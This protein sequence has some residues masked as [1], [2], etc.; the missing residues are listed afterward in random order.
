MASV[1]Q[2][3]KLEIS[4]KF[5][6]TIAQVATEVYQSRNLVGN[7]FRDPAFSFLCRS[8]GDVIANL[9]S[10]RQHLFVNDDCENSSFLLDLDELEIIKDKNKIKLEILQ[11]FAYFTNKL[12]KFAND[13]LHEYQIFSAQLSLASNDQHDEE[14]EVYF[15][16]NTYA[17]QLERYEHSKKYICLGYRKHLLFCLESSFTQVVLCP[18]DQIAQCEDSYESL[19][20]VAKLVDEQRHSWMPIH[21]E[22]NV[23]AK[24]ILIN[25]LQRYQTALVHS[26]SNV[27]SLPLPTQSLSALST[28]PD[29]LNT[30]DGIQHYTLAK[31]R[32]PEV[33][34]HT[35]DVPQQ[36]EKRKCDT[37]EEKATSLFGGCIADQLETQQ[38][39]KGYFSSVHGYIIVLEGGQT[40]NK[41]NNM[42]TPATPTEQIDSEIPVTVANIL[43]PRNPIIAPDV[44]W[45]ETI[46]RTLGPVINQMSVSASDLLVLKP[47]LVNHIRQLINFQYFSATSSYNYAQR[48]NCETFL[49][50]RSN[51]FTDLN[52]L[53]TRLLR[54]FKLFNPRSIDNAPNTTS[55]PDYDDSKTKFVFKTILKQKIQLQ[56]EQ[57]EGADGI[58]RTLKEHITAGDVLS[59]NIGMIHSVILRE[60]VNGLYCD[61]NSRAILTE[62]W[63]EI[64]T[65]QIT[66]QKRQLVI[67]KADNLLCLILFNALSAFTP[68]VK[69]RSHY[70]IQPD[71][72]VV[73]S[74]QI[75]Q[76][77]LFISHQETNID[78]LRIVVHATNQITKF[79]TSAIFLLCCVATHATIIKNWSMCCCN[80]FIARSDGIFWNLTVSF[81]PGVFINC[82]VSLLQHCLLE[83]PSH[84][85]APCIWLLVGMI[86]FMK[87]WILGAE[88]TKK[89]CYSHCSW[90]APSGSGKAFK[91]IFDKLSNERKS[92]DNLLKEIKSTLSENASVQKYCESSVTEHSEIVFAAFRELNRLIDAAWY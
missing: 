30:I 86:Q 19:L 90:S 8:V 6:D 85:H 31:K 91:F 22:I 44:Q 4:C 35:L 61:C 66:Q 71:L 41:A 42:V 81:F 53:S 89:I 38:W 92:A 1:E 11:Q 9:N 27:L 20:H 68:L 28:K 2:Q 33:D 70:Y 57:N 21:S 78:S 87:E 80:V 37:R 65:K 16:E 29:E 12:L 79:S 47:I 55:S 43:L 18:H 45:S 26:P 46:L 48:L 49:K 54:E 10:N 77:R 69:Q 59:F 23:L 72:P 40:V 62:Y 82:T 88:V 75:D 17:N 3:L 58:I 15:F 5:Q 50:H 63:I 76:I 36:I 7:R 24:L 56:I 64:I 39:F 34:I 13:L 60:F 32:K 51:M 83:L 25:Y 14:S 84:H 73:D 74:D 67:E 52:I